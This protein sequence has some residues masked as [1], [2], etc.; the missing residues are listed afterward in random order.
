MSNFDIKDYIRP[1]RRWWWLLA[2]ATLI[3][4]V[5]SFLY[6]SVQPAIYKSQATV[7]I[8]SN[9]Q[10]PNPTG[11]EFYLAQQLADTYA[12]IAM[13]APIRNKVMEKLGVTWLPYYSVSPIPNTQVLEIQVYDQDPTRSYEVAN[14]LVNQLILQ[15][16]AQKEQEKRRIFIDEQLEKLQTSIK[17]TEEEITKQEDEQLKITSARE[18]ASKQTEITALQAKLT[19]L[20]TNFTD[21]LA[22][23]RGAV[24]ALQLLEPASLPTEPQPSNLILN[25]LVA[26]ILGIVLA[27]GGAYL[28]EYLDDSIKSSEEVKNILNL[29]VLGTVPEILETEA[30]S[31]R[32]LVAL[33]ETPSPA[34][35][36]YRV[37]TCSLPALI[38]LY[39]RFC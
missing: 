35:E 27:S 29:T 34:L 30:G 25:V 12:D 2:V 13:R 33:N 19:T 36:A 9:I 38:A 6:S 20:R 10:D 23:T 8:G 26:S 32:R 11:A 16:P 14:E 22:T 28:L 17:E 15:G 31:S 1:L 7:M 4:M 39:A 21:L 24:N 18:L 37:L 5:S 3:A